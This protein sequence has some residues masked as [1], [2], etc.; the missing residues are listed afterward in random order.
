[1]IQKA[2]TE[3]VICARIIIIEKGSN[4]LEMLSFVSG[5]GTIKVSG[6]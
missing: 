6:Y 1:M 3:L 2:S 5:M 4:Y